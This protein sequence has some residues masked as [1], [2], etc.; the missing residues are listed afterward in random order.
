MF[1]LFSNSVR[2]IWGKITNIFVLFLFLSTQHIQRSLFTLALNTDSLWGC[3]GDYSINKAGRPYLGDM[4]SWEGVVTGTPVPS[5][6]RA[7]HSKLDMVVGLD[8]GPQHVSWGSLRMSPCPER[9]VQSSAF[10]PV[11]RQPGLIK[12]LP[13]LLWCGREEVWDIASTGSP[14]STESGSES[15]LLC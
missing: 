6:P 14:N 13:R 8:Q 9:S 12:D 7:E 10:C 3:T 5:V 15:N 11:G 2:L 1:W 4:L